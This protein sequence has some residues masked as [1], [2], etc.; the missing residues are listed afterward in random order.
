MALTAEQLRQ[1]WGAY[2]KEGAITVN[3]LIKQLY[4]PT[5]FKNYFNIRPTKNTAEDNVRTHLTRVLQKFQPKFTALG[6]MSFEPE[7]ILLERVKIN[8]TVTPDEL[9]DSAVQFLIDKGVERKNMQIIQMMALYLVMKAQEDDEM[10]EAWGG[11]ASTIIPTGTPGAGQTLLGTPTAAGGARTGFHKRIK[12]LNA[13]SKLK[14][15]SMGDWTNLT[16]LE[17]VEYAKDF[18]MMMDPLVRQDLKWIAGNETFHLKFMEGMFE[19]YGKV[20]DPQFQA[21][22]KMNIYGTQCEIRKSRA[23]RATKNLWTTPYFNAVGFVKQP[24]NQ[25]FF[26]VRDAS[27]YEVEIGT[28]W[29]EVQAILNSLQVYSNDLEIS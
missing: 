13:Q 5:E 12:T 11:V 17:T 8:V 16:N 4:Q 2:Y 15:V 26:A 28:D 21:T 20:V 3:N 19:K 24:E 6:D 22:G 9:A 18:Y 14:V 29:Y 7:R 23:Q 25:A 27:F 10:D 1:A